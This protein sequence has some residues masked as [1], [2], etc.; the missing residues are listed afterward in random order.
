MRFLYLFLALAYLGISAYAQNDNRFIVA[1]NREPTSADQHTQWN[2]TVEA[3]VRQFNHELSKKNSTF[4]AVFV[5]KDRALGIFTIS[6]PGKIPQKQVIQ[7]LETLFKKQALPVDVIQDMAV[8]AHG[9]EH[10][11]YF[12]NLSALKGLEDGSLIKKRIEK[13]SEL[14][15]FPEKAVEFQ[16]IKKDIDRLHSLS[17]TLYWH[18]KTP[19]VG[20]IVDGPSYPYIPH[21]FSLYE[22]APHKGSG[23]KIAII[24]TGVAAFA[25]EGDD[26]YRKNENLSM[27]RDFTNENYN[28]VSFEGNDPLHQLVNLIEQFTRK[29][30]FDEKKVELIVPQWIRD[31]LIEKKSDRIIHYLLKH[32]NTSLSNHSGLTEEGTKA[33][34]QIQKAMSPPRFTIEN[35]ETP[36]EK[37]IILQFLPAE[38]IGNSYGHG[39]HVFG[40]VAAHPSKDLPLL[41][42]IAPQSETMMFKAMRNDKEGKS[43]SSHILSAF[44]KAIEQDADIVNLS[45]SYDNFEE[46]P[47]FQKKA[48]GHLLCRTYQLIPYVVISTGNRGIKTEGFPASLNCIHFD[49][50]AFDAEGAIAPFSQY[51]IDHGPRFVAPGVDILSTTIVP[52]QDENSAYGIMSGTSMA[53]PMISAFLALMLGEFKA[54]FTR[55]QLT[56]VCYTST[57]KLKDN[58]DWKKKVVLGALDMRTAL[59]VLHVLTECKKNTLHLK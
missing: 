21:F 24:D 38:K 31:Y 59:F 3:V 43:L 28:V 27:K 56:R 34:A 48:T 4:K 16:N 52:Q 50:G 37:N 23:I 11:N 55:D 53:A 5:Q 57:L 33:L 20:I 19:T 18:Y 47:Y 32:G 39:S 14:K 7:R 49:V 13:L 22:L 45:I 40:I 8:T 15:K 58:N 46:L 35:L 12:F 36:P 1:F 42:G 41:K 30:N 44:R 17:K 9:F 2:E 6:V 29:E 54:I 25:V 51:S 26:A 10:A